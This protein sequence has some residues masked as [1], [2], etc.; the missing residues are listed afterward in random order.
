MTTTITIYILHCHSVLTIGRKFHIP[1]RTS[2]ILTTDGTMTTCI[3]TIGLYLIA[4]C[5]QNALQFTAFL[6]IWRST[7]I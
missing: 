5:Q 2:E 4:L 6:M 1:Q 7:H 3:L